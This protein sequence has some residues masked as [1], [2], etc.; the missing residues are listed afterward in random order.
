MIITPV[1]AK[2][3][4]CYEKYRRER[5][6]KSDAPE[7]LERVV[8]FVHLNA[9]HRAFGNNDDPPCGCTE[10]T[11]AAACVRSVHPH[12]VMPLHFA[13]R[14][15]NERGKRA[16]LFRYGDAT[17]SRDRLWH[18]PRIC[19]KLPAGFDQNQRSPPPSLSFCLFFCASLFFSLS[20][21][22]VSCFISFSPF[23]LLSFLLSIHCS[24]VRAGVSRIPR[25]G[26][27]A[28]SSPGSFPHRAR[29]FPAVSLPR[30]VLRIP[31][32]YALHL[33]AARRLRTFGRMVKSAGVR[34]SVRVRR[35][36]GGTDDDPV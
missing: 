34:P 2:S 18:L 1:S 32:T 22:P 16:L 14:E 8:R 11:A 20:F 7:I 31:L 9:G 27:E 29:V 33:R 13:A 19:S 10:W 3:A 30:T 28:F 24:T 12:R 17:I 23:L 5:R 15:G 4:Y 35:T 36:R 21:S 25:V 26:V 6:E